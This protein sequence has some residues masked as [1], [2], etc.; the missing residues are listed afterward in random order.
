MFPRGFNKAHNAWLDI[1]A[2]G[3]WAIEESAF[4]DVS[5]CH[6]N[7]DSY[8]NLTPKQI[9]GQH[10]KV[11][12]SLL[13]QSLEDSTGSIYAT[14]IY[15]H[16][17]YVRR[18]SALSLPSRRTSSSEKARALHSLLPGLGNKKRKSEKLLTKQRNAHENRELI[19]QSWY[20]T[21]VVISYHH[22]QNVT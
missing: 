14:C 16:W 22:K 2:Q 7:T 3:F 4:F 8:K 20:K 6:S 17:R 9:Y 1:R 19:G 15:I 18:M 12:A 13:F 21:C 11:N 5:V 10:E